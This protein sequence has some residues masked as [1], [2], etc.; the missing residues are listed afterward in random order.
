MKTQ[1]SPAFTTLATSM[2]IM[3]EVGRPM[4]SRNIVVAANRRTAGIPQ[5]NIAST[6]APSMASEGVWP[7]ASSDHSPV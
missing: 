1:L 5:P 7:R 2:K 4:A 6:P 3:P